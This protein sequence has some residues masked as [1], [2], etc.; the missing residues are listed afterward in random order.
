MRKV[1]WCC[2]VLLLTVAASA[3]TQAPRAD[4]PDLAAMRMSITANYMERSA[5]HLLAKGGVEVTVGNAV[6]SSKEAT[7]QWSADKHTVEI[8][9]TGEVVV[10][11]TDV[12]TP[13]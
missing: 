13:K 12:N 8:R 2:G 9:P 3:Q 10:R 1:T 5:D 6:I 11:L 4:Q 7:L